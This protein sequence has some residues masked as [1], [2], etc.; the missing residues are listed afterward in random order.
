MRRGGSPSPPIAICAISTHAARP[1]AIPSGNERVTWRT[2]FAWREGRGIRRA[3][4][5]V[6]PTASHGMVPPIGS[7]GQRAPGLS[8][9]VR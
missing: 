4:A 7:G 9:W 5:S 3:W 8:I 2:F 1:A 6:G